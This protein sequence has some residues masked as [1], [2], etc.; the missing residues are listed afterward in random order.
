MNKISLLVLDD[1]KYV[2]S[3]LKRLF[4][5]PKYDVHIAS[6]AHEA[7]QILEKQSIGVII[8][9]YKMDTMDGA[10]FF[11]ITKKKWP[12]LSRILLTGYFDTQ[13]AEKSLE[14]GEIYRFLTKPWNDHELRMTVENAWKRHELLKQNKE[15]LK[16]VRSQ[17]EHLIHL[18][19][20]LKKIIENR[21]EKTVR[22]KEA[23]RAK[24][25]QLQITHTLIKRLSQSKNLKDIFRI[26]LK[27]LIKLIP[28]DD[29]RIIVGI[30]QNQHY[31]LRR[32]APPD[33]NRDIQT[34]PVRLKDI[35]SVETLFKNPLP[36]I[37]KTEPS[38]LWDK[39]PYQSFFM[40]PLIK[41]NHTQQ[42]C[43][44]VLCF[45]ARKPDAFTER[46]IKRLSD[47]ASPIAIAI[48]KMKLLEIVQQGSRQWESTFDAISDLVTVID[49][50]FNLLKANR[51][52][53]KITKQS[54]ERVIGKK[55]YEALAYRKTPC[56]NCPAKE[57]LKNGLITSENE[58]TDF[59]DKDYLSWAFPMFYPSRHVNSIVVYYRD[60]TQS[61]QLFRQLIQSEKM[62]AIGQLAGSL[63]HELNNPLTGITAFSQILMKELTPRHPLY[64][65]VTEI[66]KASLRCKNIIDNLLNFS[67]KKHGKKTMVSVNEIINYTLPLIQFSSTGKSRVKILKKLGA[68]PKIK[69]NANELGQVFLNLMLNAFQAMPHGGTLTIKTALLP[70][71]SR[72]EVI[73]ADTGIGIPKHSLSRIFDPFYTTK[74]KTRGT[75]LGL[76]VSYGIIRNHQGKILVKSHTCKGSV[77]KVILPLENRH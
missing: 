63:A 67:D 7:L 47:I 11:S 59:K 74:E 6:T 3:S 31:L 46:D 70:N 10:I 30:H 13:I 64:E 53:E 16:V 62:A 20:N 29:A 12:E 24:K 44:A 32:P 35:P 71:K 9:D 48:E 56:K 55:C 66:E 14:M 8:A 25:I 51:A 26:I 69:G 42:R 61:S 17:N 19:L 57:T 39:K 1:E 45:A 77:F 76:S 41:E 27:E 15:L 23:I 2:L 4:R 5:H 40:F 22:S 33:G 73:F 52:T 28:F 38:K 37:G 75:G 58:I 50:N 43:M 49:K 18:T 60:H 34:R 36:L 65:D 21:I 72:L 54:V 68:L